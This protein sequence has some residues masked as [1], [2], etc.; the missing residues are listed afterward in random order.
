MPA[1]R[2]RELINLLDEFVKELTGSERTYFNTE[3]TEPSAHASSAKARRKRKER[4]S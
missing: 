3:P 4:T 2:R 1:P